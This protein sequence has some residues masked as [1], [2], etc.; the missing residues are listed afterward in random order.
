MLLS[1]RDLSPES[2]LAIFY[3]RPGCFKSV[4]YKIKLRVMYVI[5]QENL[6][7]LY[8]HIHSNVTPVFCIM[9]NSPSN[10]T[11]AAELRHVNIFTISGYRSPSF[12]NR[13][14]EGAEECCFNNHSFLP[15]PIASQTFWHWTDEFCKRILDGTFVKWS[16]QIANH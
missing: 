9:E 3:L 12:T 7:V 8:F 6:W 2:C 14:A 13:R 1:E 11:V 4:A 10:L 15:L 16:A 5:R